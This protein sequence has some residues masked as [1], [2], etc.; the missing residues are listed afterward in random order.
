MPP[1]SNYAREVSSF[2]R[3]RDTTSPPSQIPSPQPFFFGS[4]T[5][6]RPLETS[7]PF[8]LENLWRKSG[9]K[10]P[11]TTQLDSKKEYASP[12]IIPSAAN[13]ATT[14]MGN[15][16]IKLPVLSEL[17]LAK[18]EEK[19]MLV[20]PRVIL[21]YHIIDPHPNSI[22]LISELEIVHRS[23]ALRL[24]NM[25][26]LNSSRSFMRS[27]RDSTG[28]KEVGFT[29]EEGAGAC[30]PPL[31]QVLVGLPP[32]FPERGP[33][34][35]SPAAGQW[36]Q[37][38]NSGEGQGSVPLVGPEQE[39]EASRWR[40]DK[41]RGGFIERGESGD[42]FAFVAEL[43]AFP[44]LLSVPLVILDAVEDFDKCARMFPLEKEKEDK[45]ERSDSLLS[46]ERPYLARLHPRSEA[47]TM[48]LFFPSL[49]KKAR[50]AYG[51]S[52]YWYRMNI[53]N[54][55]KQ[56]K[57]FSD[58]AWEKQQTLKAA[59]IAYSEQPPYETNRKQPLVLML[60]RFGTLATMIESH[61]LVAK[62]FTFLLNQSRSRLLYFSLSGEE[63]AYTIAP[64]PRLASENAYTCFSH[65]CLCEGL[66][67]FSLCPKASIKA[68]DLI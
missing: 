6:D 2:A 46:C 36:R 43:A 20:S 22:F 68:K 13:V 21:E 38:T 37:K 30:G 26:P 48:S 10:F 57:P 58:S 9:F 61:L 42:R 51:C 45:K 67:S 54:K 27:Y 28:E 31:Q 60:L 33:G 19:E 55:G 59:L 34:C 23:A 16:P 32:P 3:S 63:T 50:R 12:K 35:V 8:G 1:N 7:L 44:P 15:S 41:A 18:V 52:L 56:Y 5:N 24:G 11:E 47:S 53:S 40:E 29:E 66:K 65:A 62:P 39:T 4:S 17:I 64:F 25:E 49:A 14:E